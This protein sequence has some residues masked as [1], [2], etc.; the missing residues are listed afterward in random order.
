M[1][2]KLAG[3]SLTATETS[4]SGQAGYYNFSVGTAVLS[5]RMSKT[6]LE[7][8]TTSLPVRAGFVT[9]AAIPPMTL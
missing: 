1:D 9:V 8:T 3:V 6:G 7:L 5:L 2:A 4:S